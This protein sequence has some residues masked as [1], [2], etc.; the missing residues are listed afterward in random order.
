M[1]SWARAGE[2]FGS[3]QPRRLG[4]VIPAA[5]INMA[6]VLGFFL[7][8][9]TSPAQSVQVRTVPL[10]PGSTRVESGVP[11][12]YSHSQ[13]GAIDAATAYTVSLN[14]PMLLDLGALRAAAQA[15]AAPQFRDELVA[16]GAKGLQAVNSAY[17]VQSNAQAGATPAVK[18]VPIAYKVES[19]DPTE[20]RVSMWAVWLIAEQG[21]LAP[22]QNW[23]TLQISLH[24]LDQD[25][26]MVASGAHPGPVPQPP[27]GAVIEQS[28]PLPAPLTGDYT[29]YTHVAR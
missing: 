1:S 12:G 13:A 22:Q 29:D 10:A 18:L 5:V 28:Q 17:G 11:V 6:L 26:K 24:W 21:I 27:Q 7:G 8:R 4:W 15:I 3:R 9:A 16:E 19:Y 2:D 23:I 25:W 14:G 20:A